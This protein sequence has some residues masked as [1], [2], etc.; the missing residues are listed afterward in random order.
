MLVTVF[1]STYN[2][3]YVIMK[4]YE[5]LL[6]QKCM[7]FEWLVID[8]GST[9]GTKALFDV[10]VKDNKIPINYIKTENG[11]K[12]R[13]INKGVSLAQGDLFF[14]VDSDDYLTDDAISYLINEW[15]LIKD[16]SNIAGSCFRKVN[17]SSGIIIG[18]D[19][20]IKSGEYSSIEMNYKL[21]ILGD[22]AEVF[23]TSVLKLFPFPEFEKE[24]FVPEGLVW[25]RISKKYK[26]R[27]VNIGIYMCE[28][29]PDGLSYNFY[30]NLQKNPKGFTKF[31]KEI[32]FYK[33]IPFYVKMKSLVRYIQCVYFILISKK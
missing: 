5:S 33:N 15:E 27:F 31:Y 16:K 1:T 4:L 10:F 20:D 18:G 23:K 11:G 29:L 6:K 14:I 9:D 32:L 7:S 24:N 30:Q 2:R 28:Y 19:C 22:K 25:N 21:G 8:D 17:Y 12:Q 13:A 3:A 26:L